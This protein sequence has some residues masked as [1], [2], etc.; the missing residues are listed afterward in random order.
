VQ[1]LLY[2]LTAAIQLVT[3]F[4]G[5][6][7]YG[8]MWSAAQDRDENGW[9]IALLW[10]IALVT[11]FNGYHFAGNAL[12]HLPRTDHLSH[13]AT[14]KRQQVVGLPNGFGAAFVL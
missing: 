5:L 11:A 8:A 10:T 12:S 3:V 4:I 6:T 1:F 2:P 13:Q 14:F 7:V 9:L